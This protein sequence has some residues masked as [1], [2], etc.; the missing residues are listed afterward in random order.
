MPGRA[1]KSTFFDKI[2]TDTR[3]FSQC[4]W[5]CL[6]QCDAKN[7][8]YCIAIALNHARKGNFQRGFAFS[9]S[10]AYRI[11]NII[12][13]KALLDSLK[14]EYQYAMQGNI[15]H[16]KQKYEKSLEKLV[17]FKN[18]YTQMAEKAVT[19]IKKKY[20][21]MMIKGSEY[22]KQEYNELVSKVSKLKAEYLEY[23]DQLRTIFNQISTIHQV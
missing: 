15:L 5:N 4:P 3:E 8:R 11:N 17:Y 10:N 7:A 12:S 21:N 19:L 18:E 2:D 16:L 23:T 13:V 9:G 22:M 20:D 14:A 6:Q 1:I